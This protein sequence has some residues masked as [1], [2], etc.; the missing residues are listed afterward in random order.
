[1]VAEVDGAE[2]APVV[3]VIASFVV[4]VVVFLRVVMD[5]AMAM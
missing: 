5:V 3:S 4:R 2:L 1:L